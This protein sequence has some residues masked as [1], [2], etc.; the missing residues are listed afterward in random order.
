MAVSFK[1]K[2]GETYK[3]PFGKQGEY[4]QG[5]RTVLRVEYYK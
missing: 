3:N 2:Q 4:T 1:E 5:K